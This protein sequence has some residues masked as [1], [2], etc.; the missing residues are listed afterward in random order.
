MCS[1]MKTTSARHDLNGVDVIEIAGWEGDLEVMPH[2]GGSHGVSL[3]APK[4]HECEFF[5]F[6]RL[7]LGVLRCFSDMIG[8]PSPEPC[9]TPA[10]RILLP[11]DRIDAITVRFSGPTRYSLTRIT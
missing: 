2:L 9:G 4:L 1:E 7:P 6:Q 11:G 8:T 3:I 5:T 10:L